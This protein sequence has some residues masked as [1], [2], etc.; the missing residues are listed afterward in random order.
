MR[1]V[2][3]RRAYRDHGA[4]RAPSI[5]SR[6]IHRNQGE[7]RYQAVVA[8]NLAAKRRRKRDL[9]L[10]SNAPLWGL[11]QHLICS[12]WF[13]Q[14]I[15][16]RLKTC[17]ADEAGKRVSHETIYRTIYALP[18]GGLRQ[19]MIKALRQKHKLRRLRTG[20]TPR[21]KGPCKTLRVLVTESPM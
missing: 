17:F 16:G 13:P 8:H 12:G 2:K 10:L 7:Q 15:S 4:N 6:E 3:Y 14:Q 19:E 11:T 9:K 1:S 20:G 18:R 5:I 21:G